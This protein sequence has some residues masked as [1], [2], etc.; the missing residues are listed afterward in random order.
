MYVVLSLN[1]LTAVQPAKFCW[2]KHPAFNRVYQFVIVLVILKGQL[3]WY[4]YIIHRVEI[5]YRNL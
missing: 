3:K 1:E 2:W 4:L 5:C